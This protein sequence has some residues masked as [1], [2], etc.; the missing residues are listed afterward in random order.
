MI[1]PTRAIKVILEEARSIAAESYGGEAPPEVVAALVTALHSLA[2]RE[3]TVQ[4][5]YDAASQISRKKLGTASEI[6]ATAE[7]VLYHL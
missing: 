4:A 5:L 2:V 6:A 1:A 3:A 7:D